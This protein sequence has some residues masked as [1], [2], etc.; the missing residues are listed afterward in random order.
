MNYANRLTEAFLTARVAV[1]A[2]LCLSFTCRLTISF[3]KKGTICSGWSR[4]GRHG[5]GIAVSAS[6][7]P[8][9]TPV[10]GLCF[11]KIFRLTGSDRFG[12]TLSR[13]T[14]PVIFLKNIISPFYF[15][16]DFPSHFLI[17][18]DRTICNF[19]YCSCD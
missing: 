14:S 16:E 19:K 9:Q 4:N 6:S 13:S 5:F 10:K 17:S 11:C 15:T 12:S 18:H 2:D 8:T 7:N 1:Y 3:L